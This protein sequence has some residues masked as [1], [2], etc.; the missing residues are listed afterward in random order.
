MTGGC[1]LV[2]ENGMVGR[3]GREGGKE[4]RMGGCTERATST[5]EAIASNLSSHRCPRGAA[6]VPVVK[7]ISRE[8]R[9]LSIS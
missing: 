5:V 6:P 8:E 2:S 4:G 9:Y 3:H 1:Q 7:N